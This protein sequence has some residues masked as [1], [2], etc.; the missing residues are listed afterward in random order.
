MRGRPITAVHL[1]RT[2][3]TSIFENQIGY[4]ISN[5]YFKNLLSKESP[6]EIFK[7]T[8]CNLGMAYETAKRL[9]ET[10]SAEQKA[11]VKFFF[12]DTEL[13]IEEFTT[14]SLQPLKFIDVDD[15]ALEYE[16][17]EELEKAAWIIAA[18]DNKHIVQGIRFFAPPKESA[19]EIA[20][21]IPKIKT[22][23]MTK[24]E[25]GSLNDDE[26]NLLVEMISN[27]EAKKGMTKFS[28]K[29]NGREPLFFRV[30][31][32]K[33]YDVTDAIKVKEKDFEVVRK[34]APVDHSRIIE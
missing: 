27:S 22:D 24:C 25:S 2:A 12:E 21:H 28:I 8:D 1:P 3:K 5:Q 15:E 32:G 7:I 30:I 17:A 26:A 19:K 31:E 29:L 13:P 18:K 20:P 23:L 33:V 11:K 9:R 10:L 6:F 14:K 34:L 4:K 16:F